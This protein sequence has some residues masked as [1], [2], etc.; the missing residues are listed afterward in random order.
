MIFLFF[1]KIFN[2]LFEKKNIYLLTYQNVIY[3]KVNVLY[4]IWLNF[5]I[6][7]IQ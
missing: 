4:L 1:L 7:F 6:F 3:V 2:F 5:N